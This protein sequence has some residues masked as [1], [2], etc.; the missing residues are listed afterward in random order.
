[1]A[2]VTSELTSKW[3]TPKGALTKKIRHLGLKGK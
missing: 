1:M 2:R 3:L